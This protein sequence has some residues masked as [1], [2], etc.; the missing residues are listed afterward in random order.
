MDAHLLDVMRTRYVDLPRW[1]RQSVG[2]V[3]RLVPTSFRYGPGYKR[4]RAEIARS[5]NDA[6]FVEVF[7]QL[8]LRRVLL[9]AHRGSSF[10]RALIEDRLGGANAAAQARL[11]DLARLPILTRQNVVDLGED[12]RV[13]PEANVDVKQTSGSTTRLPAKIYLDK[14]RSVREAAFVHSIWGGTGF[15]CGERQLILRDGLSYVFSEA[16]PWDLDSGLNELRLSPYHML[17]DVMDG[18]L[19]QITAWRPRIVYGLPS[20]LAILSAHALHRGWAPPAGIKGVFT[21]SETLFS[22]QR[23]LIRR[24][25][26]GVP[27]ASY[28]GLTERT[29]FA[30]EVPGLPE[31]FEFEPLYGITELVDSDDRPVTKPGEVGRIIST[32]FI[33]RAM[34]LVR[35]DTGD[36]ARLVELPSADNCW[37]LRVSGIRSKWSQEFVVARKGNPLS[38][39]NL[40]FQSHVGLIRDYQFYQDTPGQIV[41]RVVPYEGITESDIAPV[42][43]EM[44]AMFGEVLEVDL[45]L[46]DEIPIGRNGKKRL[47]DQ[48]LALPDKC[49]VEATDAA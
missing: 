7:Q 42:L 9:N 23:D 40:V 4:L 13:V 34:A 26:G 39:L 29:A 30:G 38:V 3:V 15:K 16:K 1:M 5:R 43:G 28:Y 44:R 20:A 32:G 8:N 46:I 14:D 19:K 22:P 18:Y 41:F 21:S 27:V 33:S 36:R 31:V 10:Y 17:P 12:L 49:L 37:R 35:Y 24:A 25:F 6:G 45:E 11:D 48:R 47:V 2:P